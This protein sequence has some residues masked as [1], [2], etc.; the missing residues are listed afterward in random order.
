MG[1]AK[2]AV[3]AI[4]GASGRVPE[5]RRQRAPWKFSL[6][7]RGLCLEEAAYYIG[8]SA[9]KFTTMINEGRMPLAKAAGGRRIW[10]RHALDAAFDALPE[11][12]SRAAEGVDPWSEMSA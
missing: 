5:A 3:S 12:G 11:A 9:T 8:V 6:E 4:E 10:C 2:A 1:L 7:P